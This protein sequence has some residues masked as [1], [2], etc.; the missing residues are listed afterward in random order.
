MIDAAET[1]LLVAADGDTPRCGQES[2]TIPILPL[3]SRKA[4]SFSDSS[5]TRTRIAIRVR[6]SLDSMMP[7]LQKLIARGCC[8]RR[9]ANLFVVFLGQHPLLLYLSSQTVA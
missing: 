2:A 8:W 1:A 5:S 7:V 9:L 6:R 3:L 4:I